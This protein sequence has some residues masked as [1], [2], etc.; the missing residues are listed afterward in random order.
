M[1]FHIFA[2]LAV[3]SVF[4]RPTG[5]CAGII[6]PFEFATEGTVTVDFD[7]G[8]FTNVSIVISQNPDFDF[9]TFMSEGTGV[10]EKNTVLTEGT[11]VV[12]GPSGDLFADFHG[13][14]FFDENG[15]GAGAGK[16]TIDADLGTG[17]F[18][19]VPGFGVFTSFSEPFDENGQAFNALEFTGRFVP[20]P[21][22]LGVL[23]MAGLALCGRRQ[24]DGMRKPTTRCC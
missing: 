6:G 23:G 13:K 8:T 2:L 15:N 7:L 20:A 11:F 21:G 16:F 4:V 3:C 19:G 17:I 12:S 14:I 9:E 24:R 10:F 22:V 1:R 5:A 18:E